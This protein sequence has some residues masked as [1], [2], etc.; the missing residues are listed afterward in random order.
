MFIVIQHQISNPEKF[1]GIAMEAT[2]KLPAGLKLH[3][4]LPNEDGTKAVCVWEANEVNAVRELVDGSVGQ[5]S[6]NEYF[7]VDAKNATGLPK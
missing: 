3:Y 6:K 7:S 1:W 5:F 2:S 4:T